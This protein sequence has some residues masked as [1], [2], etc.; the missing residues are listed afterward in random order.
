MPDPFYIKD[1]ALSVIATGESASTLLEL[2]EILKRIPLSSIYHHFWGGRL[3]ETFIFPE[4]QND[5]ARWAH[6][7]LHD[8]ILSEKLGVLDPTEY[9]NLDEIREVMIEIIEQRLDEVEIIVWSSKRSRFH[10]LR[11]IVVVFDT[12]LVV[13]HP[14]ELKQIIPNLSPSSIF[15]HFI[16]AR[17]RTPTGIDDFSFLAFSIW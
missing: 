1:C 6:K 8:D 14:S 10:F 16:D 17:K 7:Y 9:A 11:S 13:N 4:F 2:K 3:R 5:F 12:P 15:Y